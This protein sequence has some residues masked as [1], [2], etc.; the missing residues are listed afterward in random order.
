M[1]AMDG[2]IELWNTTGAYVTDFASAYGA[3]ADGNAL[4]LVDYLNRTQ[5]DSRQMLVDAEI[6]YGILPLPKLNEEQESYT[7]GVG[8]SHN[9]VAILG[10][11]ASDVTCAVLNTM[12]QYT[13]GKVLPAY[14]DHL[15][16]GAA[17]S[18]IARK[19]LDIAMN[20][21]H[22]DFVAVYEAGINNNML[23]TLWVNPFN[24]GGSL[25]SVYRSNEASYKMMLENLLPLL[26]A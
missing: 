11:S 24:Q 23:V 7:A 1:Q 12:G 25:M 26:Q 5:A 13:H 8:A 15:M 4:M 3:M 9:V 6:E 20:S 10:S 22:W 19:V 14:R 17:D 16:K 18:E 2:L 21:M